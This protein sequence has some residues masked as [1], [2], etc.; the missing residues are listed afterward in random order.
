MQFCISIAVTTYTDMIHIFH[1]LSLIFIAIA[2]QMYIVYYEFDF[3]FV[4]IILSR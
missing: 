2:N 3:P 1:E 4:V